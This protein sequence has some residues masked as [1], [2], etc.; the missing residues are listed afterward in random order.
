TFTKPTSEF[1]LAATTVR[2][3]RP[4]PVRDLAQA[5]VV[6][7]PRVGHS[8]KPAVFRTMIE[9]LCG[10]RPRIELFAREP[11]PGWLSW[12]AQSERGDGGARERRDNIDGVVLH[13]AHAPP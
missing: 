5:Q 2:S 10:D 1:V 4:F 9:Q 12:G 11:A 13:P 3:G 8:R 6:L 7:A